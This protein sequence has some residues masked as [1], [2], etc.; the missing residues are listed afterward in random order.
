LGVVD[1]GGA[2]DWDASGV[3]GGAGSGVRNCDFWFPPAPVSNAD[4][5]RFCCTNKGPARQGHT[6]HMLLTTML[7]MMLPM[8][9]MTMMMMTKTTT[10][11]MMTVMNKMM[12]MHGNNDK[13]LSQIYFLFY[14][15]NCLLPKRNMCRTEAAAQ[16]V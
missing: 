4:L 6:I 16:F 15:Y 7:M 5:S 1:P 12:N 13:K 8:I 3:A 9:M 10:M 11:M 2:G 14:I